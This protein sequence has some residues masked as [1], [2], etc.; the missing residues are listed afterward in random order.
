MTMEALFSNVENAISQYEQACDQ[1]ETL[2]DLIRDAE[3]DMNR[4]SAQASSAEE[5]SDQRAALEQMREAAL[6]IQDYQNKL[7]QVQNAKAQAARYLQATRS[8]LQNVIST[9]EAKLPKFD[10]S[11][12]TFQQMAANPF[13]GSASAQ[14][15]QLQAKRD[16]YQRNLN[17][18]YTLVERIDSALN[19]GGSQPQKILR[20]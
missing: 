18:A 16:E 3:S 12:S 6:R 9:I 10:Q 5:P 11:I 13:G 20:R 14:I 4:Y 19:G 8:E 15:P 7:Q 17:D 1:E 2:Y